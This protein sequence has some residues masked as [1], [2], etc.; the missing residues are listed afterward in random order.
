MPQSRRDTIR[1]NGG[2]AIR[3][4]LL[5]ACLAATLIVTATLLAGQPARADCTPQAAGQSNLI[6]TCT[7]TT[8]NQGGGAPGTSAEVNAYGTG[9]ESGTVTVVSGATVSSTATNSPGI[10]I[11]QGVIINNAGATIE[12]DASAIRSSGPLTV[13]NSGTIQALSSSSIAISGSNSGTDLTSVI[14][15]VGG[16]ISGTAAVSGVVLE[17]ANYGTLTGTN[18][19]AAGFTSAAVTNY[20]GGTITGGVYGVSVNQVGQVNNYGTIS[21][22]NQA[23]VNTGDNSTVNNYAG[24]AIM[25]ITGLGAHDAGVSV[26]AN[27]AINNWGTI[28]GSFYGIHGRSGGVSIFNSG[29]LSATVVDPG[30]STIDAILFTGSGNTLTLGPGSTISGTVLGTGNDTFQLGGSGVASFDISQLAPAAQYRGFGTFNKIGDSIWTLTG[31]SSFGGPVSVNGGTLAVNGDL[32]SVGSL[33]VNP[34]GA[35][36]G[37][38]TVGSVAV[39][40]GTLAPGNSIGTLTVAGSL[41]FTAAATYLVEVSTTAADRTNVTGTATLGGAAVQTAFAPG[42]YVAKQYAI[43]SATGG[44]S[45]SF[46]AVTTNLSPNFGVSLSYDANDVYLNLVLNFAIPGGLNTNQQNVGNALSNYFNANTNMP[47]VYGS[48]SA[49]GLSQASGESATG[50]QQAT[51]NAMSQFMGVLTDP[52]VAG[53]GEMVS[54]PGVSSYASGDA[55]RGMS[56]SKRDAYA[57]MFNKAPVAQVYDPRWSVWAAGFGGSQTTDGNAAVG[58]SNTTSSLAGV[59]VGADYFFSPD[60]VA[61]F[62]LAG[63]GTS[64]NVGDLGS[65]RSDLFQAGAFL[66]HRSGPAYISVALAYGFQDITTDRIVSIAGIDRLHAAFTANAYS[67]RIEG[68][69]RVIAPWLLNVGLTPYAAAQFTT[70]DL[71]GYAESVAAGSPTFALAYG[72][73]SVTDSRSEVGIRS[74]KAFALADALLTLRGRLAWAHDYNPNRSIGA[75]FQALPGAS[76]VVSG[77]AQPRDSALTTASA[78]LRWMNGWSTAATF[79]GEF[80]DTV[81]SYAGKGTVRYS[82]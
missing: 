34:G 64:F 62:A 54:P 80:A 63:G 30:T 42:N 45:G 79:E 51:F 7:G 43:L 47:S 49:A 67:G 70:F 77:A 37:T 2:H 14:N 36:G 31:T 55:G 25:G 5:A 40:G 20:A 17:L 81:R 27:S 4:G 24:G 11:G 16:S 69:S 74:D 18:F 73:Q 12:G 13:I 8:I 23:G 68:G 44:V 46:G 26:G 32:T 22:A 19:G 60:T 58:S 48:L 75:T 52:F 50:S 82:W 29:S 76:F 56:K 9:A 53:R 71:P 15:N 6:A 21:G 59:A 33:T 35:L 1:A 57:M 66:R 72:A 38:G 3:R 10:Y 61:G 78:E 28:A 41:V 65:G 39:N